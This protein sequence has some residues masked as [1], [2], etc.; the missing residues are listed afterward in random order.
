MAAPSRSSPPAAGR[1]AAHQGKVRKEFWLD[2]QLLAEAQA[3]L[4]AGTERETV[5]LA[6]DLVAFRGE[7]LAGAKALRGLPLSRLD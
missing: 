7:L 1:R 5:E 4:G 2:P 6:L 3:A